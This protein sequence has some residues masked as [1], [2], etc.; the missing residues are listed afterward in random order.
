MNAEQ[1][2]NSQDKVRGE[3]G[4][5]NADVHYLFFNIR[6]DILV[7][8]QQGCNRTS[9][10]QC[11]HV[12]IFDPPNNTLDAGRVNDLRCFE[13]VTFVQLHSQP[14]SGSLW[15]DG[16][17][18]SDRRYASVVGVRKAPYSR[19]AIDIGSDLIRWQV[20]LGYRQFVVSNILIPRS[21]LESERSLTLCQ[22]ESGVVST[23]Q[24]CILYEVFAP[25][26]APVLS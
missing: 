4:Y 16:V 21:G 18:R 3:S 26:L 7:R 17:Y 24:H 13:F 8:F 9:V 1:R 20:V 15:G 2:E 10:N 14:V 22:D 6:N 25:A 11:P 23:T 12:A 5:P 19:V